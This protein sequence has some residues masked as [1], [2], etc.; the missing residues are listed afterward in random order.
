MLGSAQSF[1]KFE[2]HWRQSSDQKT[3]IRPQQG[4]EVSA[5]ISTGAK[6]VARKPSGTKQ[7]HLQSAG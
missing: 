6:S 1:L 5:C 4:F 3:G 7:R 2:R